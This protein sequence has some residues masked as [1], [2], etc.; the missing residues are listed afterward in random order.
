[1]VALYVSR[2]NPRDKKIR[3]EKEGSQSIRII[4]RFGRQES[5]ESKT[6]KTRAS[7]AA[8]E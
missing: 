3:K 8:N 1:M 7:G 5:Q 6:G 4:F 2:I